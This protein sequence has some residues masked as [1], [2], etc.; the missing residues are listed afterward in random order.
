MISRNKNYSGG[1]KGGQKGGHY[2]G[3][4]LLISCLAIRD[5]GGQ[6]GGQI[7]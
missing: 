5:L 4:L 3:I 7:S 6:I 2:F 1:Q